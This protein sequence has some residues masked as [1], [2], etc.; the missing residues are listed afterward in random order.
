MDELNTP[1]G[2]GPSKPRRFAVPTI[3]TRAVAGTLAA[4]IAV[5]VL[6][7]IIA[8]D[9]MGGEP[10]AKVSITA[11]ESLEANAPKPPAPKPD[12]PMH[13]QAATQPDKP[14]GTTI[15]IIDGSSGKRQEVTIPN[16]T[17]SKRT[18]AETRLLETSRHGQIPR[19]A[20][21]GT[22]PADAYAHKAAISEKGAPD[23]PQVAIIVGGLGVSASSTADALSKLPGAVT[24]AF[25]PYSSELDTL[26]G[27][28]RDKGHEVLL[29]IPMEP[30]DYPDN[31]PG[32]Q[33]LLSS[34]SPEQNVDRLHWL[35]SRMQGY[36]GITNYMGARFT[37]SDNALAPVLREVSRRGLI[38][39]DD[40]SSPRSVAGQIAGA[41]KLPFVKSD[42]AIDAVP[43]A[44]EIDNALRRLESAARERGI[45]V[46]YSSA[47]PASIDRIAK[48]AKA[49]QSRGITLVPVSTVAVKAR[50]S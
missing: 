11:P 29:Q 6:W 35:F 26:A 47:L 21:D 20:P 2:Q 5:F 50:S 8:Q 22:R 43:S 48:W 13:E 37:A 10:H 19:I 23:G 36:V 31:D 39:V 17:D 45:A 7:A 25:T 16:T 46:G 27:R 49:A 33:T 32:P 3:A 42:V 28:A 40:A 38:Y 44:A 1:L 41:N 15:T 9:P 24:F 4:I 12:A 30:F 34:L 14:A 18:P